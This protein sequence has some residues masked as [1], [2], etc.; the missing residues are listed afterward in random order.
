MAI[1][2]ETMQLIER[3][4]ARS[5]ANATSLKGAAGE[6]AKGV[7]QYVGARYVPLFAEPLE[8]DKTKAYEPL[9]IVLHQGNSYTSRQYV[10]VG[11]E[12]T[13]E[14][15]WALTGNYNAQVEQ[16]RQ[17]VKILDGRVTAN[18]NAIET[19]TTNRIAAVTAEM[20]RAQSAERVLQSNI[21][22]ENVRATQAENKLTEDLKSEINRAMAAENKLSLNFNTTVKSYTNVSELKNDMT[23]SAGIVAVTEGFYNRGDG[24]NGIYAVVASE[25]KANDID[26][27]QCQNNLKAVYIG[28]STDIRKFGCSETNTAN[29]DIINAVI[30]KYNSIEIPNKSFLITKPV[31]VD[32]FQSV[33]S[34]NG[35]LYGGDTPNGTCFKVVN[36][37]AQYDN[38]IKTIMSGNLTLSRFETGIELSSP[39]AK[40]D[41]TGII[42]NIVF[43]NVTVN[44]HIYPVNTY[45]L[46]FNDIYLNGDVGIYYGGATKANSG[47]LI[48][49]NNIFTGNLGCICKSE[50]FCEFTF[51]DSSFDSS[52]LVFDCTYSYISCI[53]CHFEN[54]NARKD[55]RY[56]G[57]IHAKDKRTHLTMSNCALVAGTDRV[58]GS[59]VWSDTPCKVV[60]EN[61]VIYSNTPGV[62][63]M[64]TYSVQEHDNTSISTANMPN[65]AISNVPPCM[66]PLKAIIDNKL[67]EY[68][69][70]SLNNLTQGK[71]STDGE[72][73]Y[74]DNTDGDS[75]VTGNILYL[76]DN[77]NT[78][79]GYMGV[80]NEPVTDCSLTLFSQ[81]M[82]WN[83]AP[84]YDNAVTT[85]KVNPL[86]FATNALI[87]TSE[88]KS[89]RQNLQLTVAAHT[90]LK[91]KFMVS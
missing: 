22:A 91:F 84:T 89:F 51:T 61:S 81:V 31:I 67:S 44:I 24:G 57:L 90:K 43:S 35:Y 87:P 23:V 72:Y 7:T 10:P 77:P 65:I 4:V 32:K 63:K 73:F 75:K 41:V 69:G 5:I 55:Y 45:K 50:A 82:P 64:F 16:Y 48:T 88:Y 56:Y 46:S 27:L 70:L 12:L 47:E 13:N 68:P 25:D 49:F 15:F 33:K 53:N 58:G 28:T 40:Y 21:D 29:S 39:S 17:E 19:E 74:Y 78:I 38:Q 37:K 8:W 80:Y 76:T 9:T 52:C 1:D 26:V 71:F 20:E 60:I 83:G 18:A 34:N 54:L 62:E 85:I 59:T 66:P 42:E 30:V 11:V 2:T 6:I 3:I 79:F 86:S 14:S 36:T